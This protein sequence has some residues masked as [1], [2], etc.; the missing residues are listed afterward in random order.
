MNIGQTTHREWLA[1]AAIIIGTTAATLGE[2]HRRR[3]V[4]RQETTNALLTQL[5][6]IV[7][8][9]DGASRQE[10]NVLITT[11]K[12]GDSENTVNCLQCRRGDCLSRYAMAREGKN[13]ANSS[14][15]DGEI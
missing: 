8:R 6:D 3:I 13:Q 15:E 2:I 14:T 12:G 4:R 11:F 7:I 10:F 5:V 9:I 1:I